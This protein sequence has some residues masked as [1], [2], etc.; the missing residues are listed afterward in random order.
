M[1]VVYSLNNENQKIPICVFSGDLINLSAFVKFKRP[2]FRGCGRERTLVKIRAICN[3]E[4]GRQRIYTQNIHCK[5][6]SEAHLIMSE[7][8][9]EYETTIEISK[10]EKT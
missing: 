7:I 6:E 4:K 5:S 3:D 1:F 9:E 2:I 8:L 10:F